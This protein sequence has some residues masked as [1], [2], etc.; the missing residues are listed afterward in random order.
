MP[1]SRG[2]PGGGGGGGGEL[3][4]IGYTGRLR[5]KGVYFLRS[6]Y[7]K[8]YRKITFFRYFKGAISEEIKNKRENWRK[9]GN[10]D[11]LKVGGTPP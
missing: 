8:G 5:P 2:P 4:M 9:N 6:R 7:I 11:L 3:P 10:S 1:V